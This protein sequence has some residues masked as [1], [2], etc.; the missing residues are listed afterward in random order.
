MA[1]RGEVLGRVHTLAAAPI[2][3]L[4]EHGALLEVSCVLRPGSLYTLQVPFGPAETVA[5]KGRVVR[6]FVHG[7]DRKGEE[8]VVRYRAALEFV[9]LPDRERAA[10]VRHIEELRGEGSGGFE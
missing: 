2:V 6:S 9:S 1:L 7:F 10:L 3:D 8:T 4:S 5:L